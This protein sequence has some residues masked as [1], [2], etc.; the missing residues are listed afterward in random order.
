MP[1]AVV[2]V[3]VAYLGKANG[4]RL[5]AMLVSLRPDGRRRNNDA[6][7]QENQNPT[8]RLLLPKEMSA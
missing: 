5:D 8:E 6:G 7:V 2:L 3:R 1:N 4:H